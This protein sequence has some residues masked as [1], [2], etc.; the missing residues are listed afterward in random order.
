MSVV[1]SEACCTGC[2][3]C[4]MV[5]PAKAIRVENKKAVVTNSRCISCGHCAAACHAGAVV[6]E[7]DTP[8]AFIVHEPTGSPVECILQGKRSVREFLADAVPR[9]V[10]EELVRYGEMAPSSRNT[11][12]RKYYIVTGDRVTELEREVIRGLNRKV[13]SV[14]LFLPLLKIFN[15]KK[16]ESLTSL[17]RLFASMQNAYDE[18]RH[19]VLCGAPAVICIASPVSNL[20]GKDDCVCSEQYL[21]LYAESIGLASCINGFT[22]IAHKEAEAY[23]GVDADY[24]IEAAVMLGYPKYLYRKYVEYKRDI[25]WKE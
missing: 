7:T 1:I 13:G 21:M 19:P 3:L 22:Q 23:L 18:G 17:G 14:K 5:C 4:E 12:G 8:K 10:L 6:S 15:R 20:Q 25:V 11:R 16:A 2:R 9:E 24:R